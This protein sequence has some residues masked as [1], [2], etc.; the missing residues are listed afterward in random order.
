[1]ER[2]VIRYFNGKQGTGTRAQSIPSGMDGLF[3]SRDSSLPDH[4]QLKLNIL[5]WH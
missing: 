4:P 2:Q 3:L 5:P 1:M